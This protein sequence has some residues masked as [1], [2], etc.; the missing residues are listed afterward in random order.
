MNF[1]CMIGIQTFL[2]KRFSIYFKVLLPPVMLKDAF[3]KL[4]PYFG[5]DTFQLS[6]GIIESTTIGQCQRH[7]EEA[8]VIN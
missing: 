5:L 1:A 8:G 6:H 3:L 2:K 4:F 7:L